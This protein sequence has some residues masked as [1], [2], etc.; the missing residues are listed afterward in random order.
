MKKILLVEDNKDMNNAVRSFLEVEGYSVL[1]ANSAEQA[2]EILSS[3]FSIIGLILL[4]INLPGLSG[5]EFS[6]NLQRVYSDTVPPILAMTAR[7]SVGDKLKGFEVGFKDYIV[8][9][10]DLRELLARVKVHINIDQKTDKNSTLESGDYLIDLGTQE[11]IY[12][13]E[14][15]ELTNT[16]F[17]IMQML[18]R[19]FNLL[20]KTDDMID[21]VWGGD[22][23]NPPTRIHI[24][25][26]RRKL[27]DDNYEKIKTVP[28]IGYRLMQ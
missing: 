11:F 26:L 6:E 16:E 3:E 28:G 25:N 27:S 22:T 12:K 21:E 20:V 10:F 17:R 1:T 18:V 19:N 15:I 14:T 2:G 13:G 9:P 23:I 24:A 7:D 5:F 8:K 4:D